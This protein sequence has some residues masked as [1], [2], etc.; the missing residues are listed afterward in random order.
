MVQPEY[1]FVLDQFKNNKINENENFD[2]YTIDNVNYVKNKNFLYKFARKSTSND[3]KIVLYFKCNLCGRDSNKRVASISIFSNGEYCIN[4]YH[5]SKCFR[6]RELEKHANLNLNEIKP[7]RSIREY[8]YD[9]IRQANEISNNLKEKVVKL[10]ITEF[11]KNHLQEAKD[12]WEKII[13][14][15][16]FD[17]KTIV[18]IEFIDL[19]EEE[20]N[21]AAF[22]IKH[23]DYLYLNLIYSK[24]LYGGTNII[25]EIKISSKEFNLPIYLMSLKNVVDYYKNL[26]FKKAKLSEVEI[27]LK[28]EKIEEKLPILIYK[29]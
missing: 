18:Y 12:E 26:G 24:G 1:N 17:N 20:I 5:A 14:K 8:K 2:F 7:I 3:G 23:C 21:A 27:F 19:K 15:L 29:K 28:W 16:F 11:F 13:N 10:F 22:V 6:S 25:N 4:S 9:Y